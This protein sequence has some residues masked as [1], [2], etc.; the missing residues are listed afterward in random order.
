MSEIDVFNARLSAHLAVIAMLLS[1]LELPASE[2]LSLGDVIQKTL[3]A[4]TNDPQSD[5]FHATMSA[6]LDVI[7]AGALR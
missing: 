1:R 6:E 2:F 7:F 5:A 4:P 3:R